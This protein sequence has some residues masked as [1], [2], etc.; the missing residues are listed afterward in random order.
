MYLGRVKGA[1][2][3]LLTYLVRTHEDVAGDSECRLQ[4]HPGAVDCHDGS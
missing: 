2:L 4:L 1:A 3:I